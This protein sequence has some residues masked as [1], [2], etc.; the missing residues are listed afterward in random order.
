MQTMNDVWNEDFWGLTALTDAVN[1]LPYVPKQ[2]DA[3]GIFK[4]QGISTLTV[5]AEYKNGGIYLV[6]TSPRGAPGTPNAITKR[7]GRAFSTM[8][9]CLNDAIKADDVQ[10]VR[11]FGSA[12]NTETV[13]GRVNDKMQ[14]MKNHISATL[15]YHRL[16]ALKGCLMDADGTTTILNL[17]TEF[18]IA[19]PTKDFDFSSDAK[20]VRVQCQELTRLIALELGEYPMSGVGVFCSDS[21]FDQLIQHESVQETY[22]N[23]PEALR[24]RDN[25]AW[26][27]FTFAGCTFVNYRG[28][29]SSQHF[30]PDNT[31]RAFPL[32]SGGLFGEYYSPADYNETVNTIG[33]PFYAKSDDMKFNKGKEIEVQSNPLMLC[34]RPQT[35]YKLT[36]TTT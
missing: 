35:L 10:G 3:M 15:E 25:L 22:K 31:A 36:M 9:L 8:H 5:S 14:E 13:Q 18:G 20:D 26:Q 17:Y 21:W 1:I 19:E 16:G 28:D 33:L 27:T 24:L 11:A 2:C 29:V 23:Y 30:V 32:G 7:T 12:T 34:H 6:P 4:K